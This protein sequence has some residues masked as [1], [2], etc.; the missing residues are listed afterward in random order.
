M[1]GEGSPAAGVEQTR[2]EAVPDLR[3]YNTLKRVISWRSLLFVCVFGAFLAARQPKLGIDLVLGGVAGILNMRI[4]MRANERLLGGKG[5]IGAQVPGHFVRITGVAAVA[6][7][8]A[9]FGPRWGMGIFFAGFF[10]P[11]GLYALEINR[12][13]KSTTA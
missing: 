5:S 2:A 9:Y 4:V 10:L 11:V 1:S 3:F 6:A 12:R 7:A 13:Y 8:T